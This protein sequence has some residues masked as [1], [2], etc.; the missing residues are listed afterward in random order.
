MAMAVMLV[1]STAVFFVSIYTRTRDK[2][3]SLFVVCM[4][5][6]RPFHAYRLT[7][8][9]NFLRLRVTFAARFGNGL[10]TFRLLRRG[11]KEPFA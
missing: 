10:Q 8:I 11:A 6:R 9:F 3:N 7:Q 5:M 4:G 1:T 2:P